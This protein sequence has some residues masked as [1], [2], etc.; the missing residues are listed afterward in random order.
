M[1]KLKKIAL[2]GLIIVTV[3]IC[4]F[5]FRENKVKIYLLMANP[6]RNIDVSVK[7]DNKTVFN[8]SL[9]Y[10]P[11]KAEIVEKKLSFGT[12]KISVGSDKAKITNQRNIFVFFDQNIV[13][14]YSPKDEINQN[15]FSIDNSFTPFYFE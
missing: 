11:Y 10:H 5:L 2:I 13:I 6:S 9:S 7:I 4:Y 3:I 12:Y 8:D 1:N 14:Q 15:G